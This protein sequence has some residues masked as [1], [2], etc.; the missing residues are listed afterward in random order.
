M[1]ARRSRVTPRV[2]LAVR[3]TG[4]D[5]IAARSATVTR[6]ADN[7]ATIAVMG[8]A[9]WMV[10]VLAVV[11]AIPA[12]IGLYR[13][14]TAER[15]ADRARAVRKQTST[16][17]QESDPAIA[18]HGLETADEQLAGLGGQFA[19]AVALESPGDDEIPRASRLDYALLAVGILASTGATIVGAVLV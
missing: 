7:A 8:P 12:A 11:G 15:R 5:L 9:R 18:M 14:A 13:V 3:T 19:E 2:K 16:D 6:H 17:L 10:T 4:D 1:I